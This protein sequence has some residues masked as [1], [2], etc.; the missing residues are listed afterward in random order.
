MQ[1]AASQIHKEEQQYKWIQNSAHVHCCATIVQ[2]RPFKSDRPP[3]KRT[4]RNDGMTNFSQWRRNFEVS[5]AGSIFF[6]SSSACTDSSSLT[7]EPVKG[8]DS[9][10]V[11]GDLWR[12]TNCY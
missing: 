2:M 1:V 9:E 4:S 11:S 8:G 6:I 12:R 5:N 10:W 7:P 3:S